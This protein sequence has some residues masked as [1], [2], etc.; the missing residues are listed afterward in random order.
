MKHQLPTLSIAETFE[1]LICDLFNEIENTNTYKK[2]G[3]SG[4]KQK[5]IDIFSVE[6]DVAIQCKKKDLTRRE[7]SI[8]QELL[9]DIEKD[10]NLILN[11]NLKIK[12]SK[13]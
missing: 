8:R 4:H 12:I 10:V 7:I 6:K 9:N 1:D 13:L 11:Q 5:G 3:K 2:F